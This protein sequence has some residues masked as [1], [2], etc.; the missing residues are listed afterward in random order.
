MRR[1]PLPQVMLYLS[2]LS[3]S[4]FAAHCPERELAAA[5]LEVQQVDP[6]IIFWVLLLLYSSVCQRTALS[7]VCTS[8]YEQS[9]LYRDPS[10][11]C[12][13]DSE[14]WSAVRWQTEE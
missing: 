7:F 5:V 8:Y 9:L 14:W 6:K 4:L 13:E 12:Y 3:L 11:V 2:G 10:V 1:P